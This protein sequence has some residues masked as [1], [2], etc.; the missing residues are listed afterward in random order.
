MDRAELAQYCGV[1][2]QEIS[3]LLRNGHIPRGSFILDGVRGA[4]RKW[5]AADADEARRIIVKCRSEGLLR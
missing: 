2:V 1:S 3:K 4:V 5:T